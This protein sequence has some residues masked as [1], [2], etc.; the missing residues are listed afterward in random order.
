[1]FMENME[2]MRTEE[3]GIEQDLVMAVGNDYFTKDINKYKRYR[4]HQE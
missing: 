3:I 2:G 4:V 1:M